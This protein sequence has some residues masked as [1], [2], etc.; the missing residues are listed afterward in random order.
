VLSDDYVSDDFV[1]RK[2][3]MTF[4]GDV[5]TPRLQV[6]GIAA[7]E[8]ALRSGG[9]LIS[10]PVATVKSSLASGGTARKPHRFA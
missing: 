4:I 10:G 3:S 9:G 2:T 6:R 8:Q 1:V 5:P 7:A